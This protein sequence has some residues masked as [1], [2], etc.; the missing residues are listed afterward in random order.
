M[1]YICGFICCF[2]LESNILFAE[3]WNTFDAKDHPKVRQHGLNFTIKYPS[4][5]TASE[6]PESNVEIQRFISKEKSDALLT[7]YIVSGYDNFKNSDDTFNEDIVNKIWDDILNTQKGIVLSSKKEINGFPVLDYT[8]DG[9]ESNEGKRFHYLNNM[10]HI[11][12]N[13]NLISLICM[14]TES[15]GSKPMDV[16]SLKYINFSKSI[17][18]PYFDSINISM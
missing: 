16:N 3:E 12:T 7:I 2:S 17:C 9:Y 13:H 1:L 11:I 6:I 8:V 5:F 14:N 18:E 4:G 10:R 15:P